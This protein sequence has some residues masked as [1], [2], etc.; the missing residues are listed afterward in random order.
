[1]RLTARGGPDVI[2][3]V[4]SRAAL[5]ARMCPDPVTDRRLAALRVLVVDSATGAPLRDVDARVWWKSYTG[6]VANKNLAERVDGVVARLDSLGSFTVCGLPPD[7]K[8]YVE[9]PRGAKMVFSDSLTAAA[10]EIG[11]RVLRVP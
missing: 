7:Q 9:S 3:S 11:W 4:P 6:S 5:A 8:V 1:V 10:G 2:L